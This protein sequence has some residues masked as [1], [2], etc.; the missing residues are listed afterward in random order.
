MS[1]SLTLSKAYIDKSQHTGP[2]DVATK[3]L[4]RVEVFGTSTCR[5]K[6]QPF[7]MAHQYF[8]NVDADYADLWCVNHDIN[9]AVSI[10]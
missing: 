1:V 4:P 7:V 5:K 10:T 3:Y 2:I 8:K 6:R 9:G